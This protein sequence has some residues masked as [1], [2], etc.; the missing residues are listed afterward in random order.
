M[1]LYLEQYLREYGI[2]INYDIVYDPTS[3]AKV[4][5]ASRSG[6]PV[7]L[8]YPFWVRANTD[9]IKISGG[10]ETIVV[11]WASSLELITPSQKIL[12]PE[13]TNL[14]I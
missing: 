4:Q 10:V 13:F 12:E 8:Q 5:F 1:H 6:A 2:R 14:I 3:N 7:A 11:P 9:N